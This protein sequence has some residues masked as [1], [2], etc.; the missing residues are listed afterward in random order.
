MKIYAQVL[1]LCPRGQ[2][3]KRVH[4]DQTGS[5]KSR[6]ATGDVRRLLHI[7]PVHL[8]TSTEPFPLTTYHL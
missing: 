6:L 5:I 8:L 2:M 3:T 1:A 4:S 7:P